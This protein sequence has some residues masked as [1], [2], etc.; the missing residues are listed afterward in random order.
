LV[1]RRLHGPMST[2]KKSK[3]KDKYIRGWWGKTPQGKEKAGGLSNR[4]KKKRQNPAGSRSVMDR[5][6]K[7][8][9]PRK[10]GGRVLPDY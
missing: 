9:C 2:S 10:G 1:K 6:G 8:K 3:G 4:K 7:K 5:K